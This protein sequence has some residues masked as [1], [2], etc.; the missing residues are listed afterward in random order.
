M[1]QRTYDNEL[2]LIIPFLNEGEEV[3]NTV[4]NLR[5]NS[6]DDFNVLLDHLILLKEKHPDFS[7]ILAEIITKGIHSSTIRK[8]ALAV[9]LVCK[10]GMNLQAVL[11]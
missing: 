9:F 10:L 6:V 4:K 1:K 8:M 2:A 5:E 11:C 7:I 3:Y